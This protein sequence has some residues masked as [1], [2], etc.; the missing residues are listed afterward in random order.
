MAPLV[1]AA[2][3]DRAEHPQLPGFENECPNPDG[4]FGYENVGVPFSDN[5]NVFIESYA[6]HQL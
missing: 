5:L 3:S 1:L 2:L 4:R 6:D